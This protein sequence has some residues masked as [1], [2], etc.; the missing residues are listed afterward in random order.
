MGNEAQC[1]GRLGDQTSIGKALLETDHVLFRG[2]F[3]CKVSFKEMTSIE[4]DGGWLRLG[5]AG[6]ELALELGELAAKWAER[7]KHPKSLIDKLGVKAGQR[8]AVLDV[9]DAE[10]WHALRARTD[11]ISEGA[12]VPDADFIFVTVAEPG[13]LERIK[14]LV[15]YLKANGG[16]WVV[17]PKGRKDLRD[18]DVMAAGKA[19]GLVDVKVV[20]F[21][22]TLTALKFVI[23]VPNRKKVVTE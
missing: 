14:P 6:T 16:V 13:Q 22:F 11:D 12:P 1:T 19:A 21:N 4:T 17:S 9:D 3:R 18:V 8:V 7:I 10:F 15:P 2:G 23:P 20:A 5:H